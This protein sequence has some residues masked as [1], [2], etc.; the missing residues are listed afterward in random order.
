MNILITGDRNYDDSKVIEATF[1]L[2]SKVYIPEKYTVHHGACK[3]ADILAGTEAIKKGYKVKEYPAEWSKYGRV[4]GPMRNIEMVKLKPEVI[5][6][7]HNDLTKSKGTK[8]CVKEIIKTD[9]KPV[10]L[11]NGIVTTNEELAKLVE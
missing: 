11:L 4:A 6:I 10:L 9:F 5:L 1:E 3:G 7:F 2:I 8:H